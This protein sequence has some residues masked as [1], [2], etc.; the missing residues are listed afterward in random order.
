[1]ADPGRLDGVVTLGVDEHIWRASHH[2]GNRAVTSMVDLTVTSTGTSTP[3]YWTSCRAGPGLPTPGGWRRSA[4]GSPPPVEHAA[5]DPFRGYANAIRNELPG[6]VAV[7]DAFHVVKLVDHVRRRVQQNTLGHHGHK[8]DPLYR[9]RAGDP[10]WEV[11][12]AWCCYQR[13]RAIYHQRT[14]ATGKAVA[15]DV[16]A[17]LHSCPIPEVVRLGLTLR[18]WRAQVLAYCDIDGVSSG[19]TEAINLIIENT[20]CLAHGF[21]TLGH[22]RLR[23]LLAASGDR[24]C[25][26]IHALIGRASLAIDI[27]SGEARDPRD[28]AVL[29]DQLGPRRSDYPH[30][31]GP[32]LLGALARVRRALR[33]LTWRNSVLAPGLR[34]LQHPGS[35]E[36]CAQ[37]VKDVA[38]A[39]VRLEWPRELV[40]REPLK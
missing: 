40:A 32:L 12:I 36:C 16:I 13:L 34:G 28:S 14:P 33:H 1:M 17:T 27:R 23:I 22:Y 31:R 21:R 7:L 38:L 6:A 3:D 2:G 19:G 30:R 35:H 4:R 5:L 37:V 11:T 26:V 9:A 15:Q 18:A 8:D 39:G 25:R 10:D 24:P 29:G 20:R